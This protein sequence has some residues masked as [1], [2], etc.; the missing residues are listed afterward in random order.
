MYLKWF[1]CGL[2]S[3]TEQWENHSYKGLFTRTKALI[4]V[5]VNNLLSKS[6]F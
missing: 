1:V 3:I 4:V 5:L 2:V 6:H